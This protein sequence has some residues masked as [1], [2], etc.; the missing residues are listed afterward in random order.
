VIDAEVDPAAGPMRLD[1]EL[2]RPAG[3]EQLRI[4]ITDLAAVSDQ[5]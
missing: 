1:P 4:V 5:S 2:K 3:L